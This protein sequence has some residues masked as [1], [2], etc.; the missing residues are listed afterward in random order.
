MTSVQISSDPAP[1]CQTMALEHGSLSPGRNC[2]ENVSH[3]DKTGTTSNELDLLFSL[4]FDELLNGSSK[5]VS[6]SSAV[7][8]A[9]APNQRQQ[10]TT[11]LNNHTTPAPTCQTPSI[12]PTVISSEN[13]NQAEPYVEND[14]TSL[15]TYSQPRCK[16]KGRRRHVITRRQ[17][18]SD[19]K[20]CMF[21]LTMSRTEP[22]N[23]KEVMAD[24][25]WIE[26][27]QEELHQFDR[28]DVWELVD[29]P[30]CTNVINLKW[31]WK[32]KPT[33][34][35]E[36]KATKILHRDAVVLFAKRIK[37]FESKLKTK[38][39]RLVLSDS[40]NEE[41]ASADPAD[42]ISTGGADH[43]DVVVSAGDA[44]SAGTFI[45]ASVSV[46]A[47]PSVASAP[48]SPIKD[49][50]KGKAIATPSSP[51]VAE[52]HERE[53]R[54]SAEESTSR[55]A[56]LDRIAL[57][58]T[59][60]EWI[61]LVDQVWT[62]QTLSA[63]L[64]GADVSEDT[65]SV[66]MVELMNQRQKEIAEMKAKAKRDKP[67]TPAQQMEYKHAFFKNQSTTVYT[68]GAV[69]LATA[70]DRHQQLK[71]SGETLESLESKKLKSSHS[72]EQSAEL[73]KI[74]ASATLAAG[75]PIS[76]VPSV[77]AIPYVS[78]VP[79]VSV[80]PSVS[81]ASS[82][83]VET[84]ITAGVSTTAG[85]FELASVPIID[86]LDSPPKATS[87]PLDP[88]TAKQA[89]PL[90]KSSRKKSMA[91]RR[92]LPRPSESEFAALPFAKDDPEAEFKKKLSLLSLALV[93]FM[94]LQ[95]PMDQWEIRSWR[96]YALPTIH[97]LET[98]AGDIMYMFVVC[99][100]LT[101]SARVLNW[102]VF[103][104]EEIVMAMMTFLKLSGVH[105]QCFTVKCGLLWLLLLLL[106][107]LLL[108][109][110]LVI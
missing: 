12:A 66:R 77:S 109:L 44:D 59:N 88:A 101:M 61:G 100:A 21:A 89:V 3:G 17:L 69:D 4:M 52:E 38:K 28:L 2:Q 33:L 106:A 67:L 99:R 73:S 22:K 55:Q 50:A 45:F 40:E 19:A 42:V 94:S 5:V 34:E 13:I 30:L 108:I 96:F 76:A 82:I 15:S 24:S 46:A 7:S 86:L 58:L 48:S 91:K 10:P 62:N 72:T 11:P 39:R 81:T 60:E 56:E 104:L 26:S 27:M 84:P 18:E 71:R 107:A 98:K 29:R 74:S 80:V 16:T 1:E 68:T 57:N 93:R 53:I 103:K 79:S 90:R 83:P 51:R 31:L 23:I 36:L 35:A 41:E 75:D 65:F 14:M 20:M 92:T 78:D 87:L 37:K 70:K 43:A 95:E 54:A 25:A 47:G 8:A 102:P 105:Y 9:D 63:K 49:P 64:L 6:K 32:N 85:V 110:T 97:V